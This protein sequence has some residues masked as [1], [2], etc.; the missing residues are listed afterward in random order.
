M[1]DEEKQQGF[2]TLLEEEREKQGKPVTVR[3]G[4]KAWWKRELAHYSSCPHVED[5]VCVFSR[6][7]RTVGV[8]N[9]SG[10]WHQTCQVYLLV[11]NNNGDPTV[12]IHE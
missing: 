2:K 4:D 1:R 10:S 5:Y 3:G 11:N 7:F 12:L 6:K 9:C 8:F